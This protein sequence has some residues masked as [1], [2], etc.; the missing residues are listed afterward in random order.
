[1]YLK[2]GD[3]GKAVRE[4]KGMLCSLGYLAAS[5]VNSRYDF[6]CKD[7]VWAFQMDNGL[8]VGDCDE[9]TYAR[10]SRKANAKC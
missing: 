1:M 10:I 8:D 9:K 6:D 3:H 4:L 7:A 5:K 2:E